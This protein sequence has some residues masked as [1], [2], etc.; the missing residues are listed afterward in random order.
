MWAFAQGDSRFVRPPGPVKGQGPDHALEVSSV[1]RRLR[2]GWL[3]IE[4]T[5][6]FLGLSRADQGQ[7]EERPGNG[8][9]PIRQLVGSLGETAGA[10]PP[11][12][13]P[14]THAQERHPP[15]AFPVHRRT[16]RVGLEDRA[17]LHA[18]E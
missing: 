18:P 2:V 9:L 16:H 13:G 6:R 7:R 15:V 17:R 10:L 5:K 4:D 12:R 1:P 8:I 14:V 11:G 3:L